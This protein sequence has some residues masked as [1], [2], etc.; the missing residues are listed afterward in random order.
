MANPQGYPDFRG[1]MT[2]SINWDFQNE[3]EFAD[4]YGPYIDALDEGENPELFIPL[5]GNYFEVISSNLV[6][7]DLDAATVFGVIENLEIVYADDGGVFIPPTMN[8]IGEIDLTEGYRVYCSENSELQ[9]TGQPVDPTMEYTL[10][11]NQWNW[12]GYPYT[13][14]VPVE[15]ALQ[16]IENQIV[17]VMSDDGRIFVP[18]FINTMGSMVPG[19][20]Y[21]IFVTED[22]TFQYH[23]A[24]L[25][26]AIPETHEPQV[27]FNDSPTPTGKP[28]AIL[29]RLSDDVRRLE[30]A[31]I[32]IYDGDLLVGKSIV[33]DDDVIPVICWEGDEE[34]SLFGFE[35]GH[36]ARIVM[37]K[38]DGTPLPLLYP[39][40]IRFGEKAY[41]SV[42]AETA[43]VPTS[44]TT[45]DAYPN[46][47][48]ST[49][50]IPF[51]LPSKGIVQFV[52]YDVLGREVLRH[53][54]S[55]HAGQHRFSLNI[56]DDAVRTGSGIFFINVMFNDQRITRKLIYMK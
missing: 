20:G 2:W 13:Y 4:S 42:T 32:E 35:K 37:K 30:P 12:M 54:H 34:H 45:G 48:N 56:S 17:I 31:I 44:F 16:E 51:T 29:V 28:Y 41:S 38:V 52:L 21:M 11:S 40:Q 18:P 8:T 14:R 49:V 10:S 46:P 33:S 5:Q 55:F 1:L 19:E 25:F 36:M 24:N 6:P 22:V 39:D 47:F 23:L 9:L 53:A 26:S 43:I 50:T 27:I 15:I 7:L 3:L